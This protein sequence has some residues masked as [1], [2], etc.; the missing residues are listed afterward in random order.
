MPVRNLSNPSSQKPNPHSLHRM[1][2][3]LTFSG[4]PIPISRQRWLGAS[5]SISVI[6]LMAGWADQINFPRLI[7][8]Q[9]IVAQGFASNSSYGATASSGDTNHIDMISSELRSR[10]FRETN[11]TATICENS[12]SI[13]SE[14]TDLEI[15]LLVDR[16]IVDL[17]QGI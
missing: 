8:D 17:R 3:H 9:S 1:E 7:P 11:A 5:V 16:N 6:F 12:A 15:R 4:N 10:L 2:F 14:G 13:N